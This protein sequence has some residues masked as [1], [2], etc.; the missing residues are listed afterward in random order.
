MS[1][2]AV[3][4]EAMSLF[5]HLCPAGC[6]IGIHIRF[7]A[8]L[9]QIQTYDKAWVDRYSAQGYALRDPTIAWA[10]SDIGNCR[11]SELPIPDTFGILSEAA[12]Y[13]LRYGVV[14][15]YGEI[16]SRTIAA[17]AHDSR[18][19]SDKEIEQLSDAVRKLHHSHV[20]QQTLTDKQQL[21]LQLIAEGHCIP[22]IAERLGISE[23][24][25]EDSL[26]A[27]CKSLDAATPDEA[28]RKA[29]NLRLI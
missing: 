11:W 29:R 26:D 23:Q 3:L 4:N 5:R 10:F 16:G 25:C 2:Q 13:G 21:L 20:P 27:A 6:F 9:M 19:F 14:V 22:V 28:I 17:F 1:Q 7:A 8:P 24:A 12:E 18:E 15:C